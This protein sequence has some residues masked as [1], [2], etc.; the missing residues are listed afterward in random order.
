MHLPRPSADNDLA[1]LHTAAKTARRVVAGVGL[2]L[3]TGLLAVWPT[4]PQAQYFGRNKV[5]WE[6]FEFEI[7]ETEHFLIH[8][9]PPDAAHARTVADLA[10]RW[11]ARLSL[12]FAHEFDEKKTLV[13][14]LNHA[15]F[16]QTVITPGLIGEGTG[17]FTESALDRVV[18]PLTGVNA[19]NDHVIGHELVHVFQF[20]IARRLAGQGGARLSQMPLWMIEGLAEYLSQGRFDPATA[21]WMRDAVLHGALP[22]PGKLIQRQPSPY[23]YGQAAW[24][25]VAGRW[26]DA[27]VRRLYL[28]ANQ[29]GPAAAFRRVLG[30]EMSQF[31]AEFHAALEAAA[32][33]VLSARAPAGDIAEPILARETTGASINI[34]PSLSPDGR[35][36]AFLSTRALQ[37]ELYLA[38]VETG[39]VIDRLV[40][41]E[42]DPHFQ[43][44][45]FIDSSVAWSPVGDRIAFSVFA[46]GKRTVALYDVERRRVTRRLDLPGVD[47]M[48]H[49]SFSPDGRSLVFSATSGAASNLHLADLETGELTVL[50]AD[51]YTAIQPRFSPDGRRIA[52]VTDR[53]AGTDLDRRMFGDLQIALLDVETRNIQLLSLFPRGKHIDPQFSADGTALYFIAE[54]DGVPDVFRYRFDDGGIERLTSLQTGAAGIT[55]VS[56]ALSV[57]AND[58]IAFSVIEDSAY[59]VYSIRS[60]KG[61]EA[62]RTSDFVAATLPPVEAAAV[63]DVVERY[64][65][66]PDT[67]LPRIKSRKTHEYRPRL[68]LTALSPATVG[69]SFGGRG[70]SLGGGISAYFSDPLNRHQIVTTFQGASVS[71]AIDIED[72]LGA[73]VTYLNQTH[74]FQW[75]ARIAHIPYLSSA[76]GYSRQEV[77]INGNPTPA[78]V[79]ERLIVVERVTELS[80]LGWYPV[81]LNSRIE[82]SFGRA[83]IS[84][85]R[86][87]ERFVYPDFAPGFM[88]EI[89]LP[90]PPSL[91]LNQATVAFVRDTS[92]FAFLSPARGMRMRLEN[93]WTSGDLDFRTTLIDYRRYFFR[94][95]VTFAAR[96]L[97]LGRHGS[98]AED[99]RLPRFDIGSNQLV[100]GY[101]I[102]SFNLAECTVVFNGTTC[103]ELSRLI[104]TR[105]AVANLELRLALL[106]T[107]DLGVFE[108]PAAPTELALFVDIGAAWSAGQSVDWSF[109]RDTTERVPVVSAGIAARTVLL[110]ALPLEFFYAY[111]F[112]RPDED[113]VFGFRIAGGW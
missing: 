59:N 75:G 101:D 99:F 15:D 56:P 74:R 60:A 24:A 45:S 53:G 98:G 19:D 13:I 4:E 110:G 65:A 83:R 3:A 36:I 94:A 107:G 57:A 22:N 5:L 72:A 17:G 90:A 77:D 2:A 26:D 20:D 9:Y 54:P 73:D 80:L 37:L 105:I 82:T 91:D 55:A 31:I 12:F 86:V 27:T 34:A 29:A 84:Y 42:A 8:Y 38:D 71:G 100:R 47:D 43:N 104:G 28:H 88:E 67:G 93:Q 39:E 61:P 18:L 30:L 21:M 41:A 78:D 52:F 76:T 113:A 108:V 40:R 7:L 35:L 102:D 106:G 95:P 10:E 79:F 11:Y 70:T 68:G 69:V 58:V 6:R 85:N 111:P 33:P 25:Y 66:D 50:T 16:Q 89:D 62:K 103:P 81:S 97:H 14:Y 1:M 51:Q 48:R 49:A 64:L 92:G 63:P 46:K 44:L 87:L 109:R 23:Q 96:L 112:Q 32:A